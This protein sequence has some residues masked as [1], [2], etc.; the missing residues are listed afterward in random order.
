MNNIIKVMSP[1]MAY[2]TGVYWSRI[3]S[4][5]LCYNILLIIVSVMVLPVYLLLYYCVLC[6]YYVMYGMI[7]ACVSDYKF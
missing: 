1:V 3:L 6:N 5:P 4:L 7:C 2:Y